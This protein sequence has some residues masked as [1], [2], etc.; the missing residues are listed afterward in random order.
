MPLMLW[1]ML[2]IF[3]SLTCD[4]HFCNYLRCLQS[5]H[6]ADCQKTAFVTKQGLF[7][8]TVLPF[9]L[10]NSPSVFQR[11]MHE[12]LHDLLGNTCM[13]FLDD[14]IVFSVTWEEH[15]QRLRQVFARLHEHNLRAHPE[16]SVIGTDKLVYLGHVI[17]AEGNSPD[18][19]K[20]SAVS[21]PPETTTD[22]RAFLGLDTTAASFPALQLEPLHCISFFVKATLL[23]GMLI[24]KLPSQTCSKPCLSHLF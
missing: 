10:K 19:N 20:V 9:G 1:A 24:A 22:L 21:Q 23:V 7:D 17:T 6:P 3:P 8:F 13:V 11:L 12:V 18:P 14:I 2:R 16:K 5:L 15:L 4:Q